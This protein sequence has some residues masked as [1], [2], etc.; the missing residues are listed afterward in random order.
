MISWHRDRE[1]RVP[2]AYARGSHVS[3]C[4]KAL[5]IE[6]DERR[7]GSRISRCALCARW[8]RCDEAREEK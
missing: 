5:R 1:S 7:Y 8:L 4:G 2:H 6:A 3:R